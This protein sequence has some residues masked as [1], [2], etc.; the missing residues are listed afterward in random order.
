MKRTLSLLL[1]LVLVLGSFS[2]VFAAMPE[3]DV[4]KAELLKELG[5]LLGNNSGDL[6]LDDDLLR[7]DAVVLLSRLMKAEETARNFPTDDM[8]FDDNDDPLYD[9]YIAWAY[10]NG[11]TIG[12]SATK[13]DPKG[14]L[15]LKLLLHSY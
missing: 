6:M 15:L 5:V 7:R 13:F 14:N 12:T 1:A 4:E 3:T 8:P 11:Y 9:G 10:A 2:T